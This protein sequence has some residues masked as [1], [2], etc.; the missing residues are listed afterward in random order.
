M[1]RG[2][3]ARDFL[4]APFIF[5]SVSMQRGLKADLNRISGTKLTGS[6]CK[7][8]WKKYE[9]MASLRSGSLVSMQRGLKVSYVSP[10]S[11]LF[12]VYV[13]MQR[14]LKDRPFLPLRREFCIVSMQRGLK[15]EVLIYSKLCYIVCLN[16]KRI[17]SYT[18]FCSS[19]C[20][21]DGLNAKRI[22]RGKE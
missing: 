18:C 8:D 7:E 6:Q 21:Q 17:E 10:W 22:E 11:P 13:S 20:A 19:L 15:V 5:S 12:S 14:G 16:A 9:I 2:L 1:Q 4:S 3:K